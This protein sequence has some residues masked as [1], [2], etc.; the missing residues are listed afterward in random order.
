MSECR[1]V[2]VEDASLAY[3]CVAGKTVPWSNALQPSRDWFARNLGGSVEGLHVLGDDGVPAGH[4]YWCGSE[5]ALLPYH[6]EPGTATVLCEWVDH[7][8]RGRGMAQDMH[9][10]LIDTLEA[11]GCKGIFVEATDEVEYMHRRHFEKR[12]FRPVLEWARGCLMYLPLSQAQAWAQAIPL[13]LPRFSDARVEVVVVGSLFCPVSAS[14]LLTLR[15]VTASFG[16]KVRLFEF[17]ASRQAVDSWGVGH[18][19]FVN[20]TER[21]IGPMSRAAVLKTLEDAAGEQQR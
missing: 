15:D 5:H 11:R 21:F 6:L 8:H 2:T 19:I 17:P 12:G 9:A 16:G 20:G 4:L 10:G 18:G 3:P 13:S 1:C 14:T 7:R